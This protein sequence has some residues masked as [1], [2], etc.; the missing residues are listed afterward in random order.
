MP[1]AK[2][3]DEKFSTKAKSSSSNKPKPIGETC[4]KPHKM[5]RPEKSSDTSNCS[6]YKKDENS[7]DN[8]SNASSKIRTTSWKK[9]RTPTMLLRT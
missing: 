1:R 3:T 4:G 7:Y 6:H 8:P 9:K 2:M 5:H